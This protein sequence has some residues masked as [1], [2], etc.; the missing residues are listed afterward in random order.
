MHELTEEMAV[1]AVVDV[2]GTKRQRFEAVTAETGLSDLDLDSIEVAELFATLED[3]SGLEL[4]PDSARA[5][6]TVGDLTRL[7]PVA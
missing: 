2:L 3:L 1:E 7:Q 4:D 6:T 5:L